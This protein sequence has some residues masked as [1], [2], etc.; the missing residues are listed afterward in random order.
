MRPDIDAGPI[1]R[2]CSDSNGL[3]PATAAWQ[4]AAA[5]AAADERLGAEGGGEGADEDE[6]AS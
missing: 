2:K 4:P 1:G 3:V 5:V 6:D